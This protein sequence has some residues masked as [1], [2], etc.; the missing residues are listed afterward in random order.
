MMWSD[1]DLLLATGLLSSE[2][3]MPASVPESEITRQIVYEQPLNERIR[4]LLRL[5][6]LFQTARQGIAGDSELHSRIG[7]EALVDVLGVLSRSDVRSD[8][9]KELER[10][11]GAM[12][13]LRDRPGVDEA[14]LQRYTDDCQAIIDR[15]R[16]DRTP[17][18]QPMRDDELIA[19]ISQR[20]GLGAA[21]CGFDVPAYQM[22][23]E[24]PAAKRRETLERWFN[25]FRDVGTAT[26]L[27]LQ[28]LRAS[29]SPRRRQAE[30]GATQ[31]KLPRNNNFQLIRVGLD[32]ELAVFPEISGSRYFVTIRFM[33]Q[34]DT[35]ERPEQTRAAIPFSLYTCAI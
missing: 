20:C 24:Q 18:G 1:N 9:I 22:W 7:I 29:A 32:P 12:Q 6:H 26:T 13:A 8:M 23:L 25:A 30:G 35:R 17:L 28:L 33:A 16:G 14:Q 10:L 5:E 15:L 19:S 4:T 27:I 2:T 34:P 21:T 11:A 3:D 31:I